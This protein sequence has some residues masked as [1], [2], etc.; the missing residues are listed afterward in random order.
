MS[1]RQGQEECLAGWLR[2][3]Q[4][5][6]R[7]TAPAQKRVD[8]EQLAC[9][10]VNR[11]VTFISCKLWLWLSTPSIVVSYLIGLV[12]RRRRRRRYAFDIHGMRFKCATKWTCTH[13]REHSVLFDAQWT[14]YGVFIAIQCPSV[15]PFDGYSSTPSL[16][17]LNSSQPS[18]PVL[19]CLW[20]AWD[21]NE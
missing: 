6:A 19:F 21:S 13:V 5:R 7:A 4:A 8:G 16:S 11:R 10:R 1:H 12:I 17:I 2:Q 3:E 20:W 9:V 14:Y 15:R 18:S